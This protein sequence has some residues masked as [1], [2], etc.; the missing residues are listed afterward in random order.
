MKTGVEV[1]LHYVLVLNTLLYR[2]ADLVTSSSL[3]VDQ[4]VNRAGKH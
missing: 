3:R 1:T 4:G 2:Y